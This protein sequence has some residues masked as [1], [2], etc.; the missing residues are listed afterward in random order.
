[1]DLTQFERLKSEL[2][3][4]FDEK[5]KVAGTLTELSIDMEG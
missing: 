5:N 1:M 3:R 4:I 2:K